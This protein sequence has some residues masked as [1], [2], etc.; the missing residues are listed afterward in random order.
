M[1]EIAQNLIQ[2]AFPALLGAVLWAVTRPLRRLRLSALGLQAAP[3]RE[4]AILLFTMFLTGL[5]ALTLT[6]PDFWT[7][8]LRGH[9]PC[10]QPPFSGGVNLIP[11]RE[12]ARLFRFYVKTGMWSAI[13]INFP[14]NIIMFLPIGIFSALLMDKPRWWKST[15]C[16]LLL[17]LFIEIF[18]LFVSRGT[19]VD[20]LILNTL[21]GLCGYWLFL[22]LRK[23][24]PALVQNCGLRQKGCA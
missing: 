1:S 14:G 2:M 3:Y 20:D 11:F 22:P 23:T 16:T 15:L 18:Q 5:L 19:D 4:G 7:Y 12:S 24:A 17:S 21:G 10:L 9:A 6:P 8:V 13:W